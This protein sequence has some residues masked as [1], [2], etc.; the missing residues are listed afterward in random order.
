MTLL[1]G[2]NARI[3]LANSVGVLIPQGGGGRI[4]VVVQVERTLKFITQTANC[5]DNEASLITESEAERKKNWPHL[6]AIYCARNFAKSYIRYIYIFTRAQRKY[7]E[8]NTNLHHSATL[9]QRDLK[10]VCRRLIVS[11]SP[12]PRLARNSICPHPLQS[13]SFSSCSFSL[14][15]GAA[16]KLEPTR[17][18]EGEWE[19]RA[20]EA[21]A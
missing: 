12:T 18:G 8:H 15:G 1:L 14:F 16:Q 20:G 2:S 10:S 13:P 19:N 5:Q 21:K 4:G 7:I 3:T 11:P 6:Y 17:G 9:G